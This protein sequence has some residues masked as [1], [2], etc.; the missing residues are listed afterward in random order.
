MKFGYTKQ[1]ISNVDETAFCWEKMLS[2]TFTAREDSLRANA[3]G[4]FT[5]KLM[6]ISHYEN[7][8]ALLEPLKIMLNL[9]DLCSVNEATKPG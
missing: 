2:V 4:D 9:L 8:R 6:V 5:L 7:P 1:Q 3:P